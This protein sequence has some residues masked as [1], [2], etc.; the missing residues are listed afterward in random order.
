M[1]TK[2]IPR[3]RK[4]TR[5]FHVYEHFSPALSIYL[6]VKFPSS[7]CLS[8][9]LTY[10]KNMA[11]QSNSFG[12]S[13]CSWK[14]FSVLV[15]LGIWA[16]AQ[17]SAA[18][19][20]FNY[21]LFNES[22]MKDFIHGNDQ[23]DI[24]VGALQVTIDTRNPGISMTNSSGRVLYAKPFRLWK[25]GGNGSS[26][27]VA[28]F[29]TTFVLNIVSMTE[30]G[31]G[32]PGEGLAFV[33]TNDRQFPDNSHGLWL[34]IANSTTNGSS[35]AANRVV[36][37]EFDTRKSYA[38]D[39][40]DNH[41]GLDINSINS[42]VQY[43]L[44]GSGVNLSSGADVVVAIR[45]DGASRN[46]T[47]ELFMESDKTRNFSFSYQIDLSQHLAEVVYVGFSG[48]TGNYTELNC[49]KKWS[50]W[51]D[52]IGGQKKSRW[53]LW[54]L[55][56]ILLPVL[57]CC[58]IMSCL[59]WRRKLKADVWRLRLA[60][61]LEHSTKGPHKFRLK[62]LRSA[63]GNFHPRNK[64]GQGGFG[65]VY[66][67]FLRG[68]NKEVAVKRVSK[69]SSQ[70]EQEF[71]AEV[72]I[73]SCLRHKNLVGLIGW[74]CEKSELLLVYEYLPRGSLDKLLFV[75][76]EVEL[77]LNWERRH[78]IICGVASALSYLHDGCNRRVLHRDVK[79]SNVMVDSEYNAR[80]GDF[81]LARTVRYDGGTHHTTSIIAGTPGYIAPEY[82]HTG[83]ASSE[84]DVY[85][86]G[87]FA[88][89][90][91]C[92]QPPSSDRLVDWVWG[93]YGEGRILDAVDERLRGE[94]DEK[95]AGDV[96]KLGLACCH[97]NPNERPSMRVALQVLTGEAEAPVVPDEKPTFMWPVASPLPVVVT[98][99]DESSVND[100]AA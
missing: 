80:L 62:D 35:T 42:V 85:G 53:I 65:T 46:M 91:V 97:P 77:E 23:S 39:G 86:F 40:E 20:S 25:H 70:G 26:A 95:Q 37:V 41:V 10:T 90:V 31:K 13:S 100:S 57:L 30:D 68:I 34:G 63:T 99:D 18:A 43:P 9:S 83:R 96:L 6:H 16:A 60:G 98:V 11:A 72:T 94:Y 61:L 44:G 12:S 81:G 54:I 4:P 29:N 47:V 48:A 56:G 64:L 55:L 32:P 58:G 89:E 33:L 2:R 87:V 84:T 73:I 19:L 27:T 69:E 24:Y 7:S 3:P 36:A 22:Q 82:Y 38:A 50:F 14:P 67:G 28:S 78:R 49:V 8:P 5:K 76:T 51:A 79:S 92:G 88:I 59:L 15:F 93:M 66:K 52:D 21:N 17:A 71:V 45:Y 1:V 75:G 74:C